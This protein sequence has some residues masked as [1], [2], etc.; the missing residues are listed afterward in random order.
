MKRNNRQFST[1]RRFTLV[2]P[3]RNGCGTS[4]FIVSYMRKD[5]LLANGV[6]DSVTNEHHI[7][8]LDTKTKK[9]SDS[10]K[11]QEEIAQ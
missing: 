4:I 9:D 3:C 10:S 2:R 7:C 8:Q 11:K 5:D 1:K 6:Y